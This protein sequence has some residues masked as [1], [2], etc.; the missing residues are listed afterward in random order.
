MADQDK[1]GTD[2]GDDELDAIVADYFAMLR[3]EKTG[4]PFVK[5]HHRRALMEQI[6]RT[7]R[8]VE[9]KHMNISAVLRCLGLPTIKGYKPKFHVQAGI[10]DAV[11]RYLIADPTALSLDQAIGAVARIAGVSEASALFEEPPPPLV[12]TNLAPQSDRLARLVRKFDPT[13]RDARNRALGRAGEALIVDFERTRLAQEDRRD[14]ASKVRWV[15]Q[16]D[17]DGAGYDI[18][19]FDRTGRERLIEVKTTH[20][21]RTT[22]FFL[23][24]NERS[25]SD[26][27]PD[28]FRLYRVYEFGPAPR[29]FKLRPPL[30]QAVMLEP[31]TYRASFR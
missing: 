15:A 28:A 23:S 19:S 4:E 25:L 8:S 1:L 22:P 12:A 21:I 6:G 13:E 20:G 26:E 9:F 10:V 3:A 7:N 14:L 17:G 31:T 29:L 18:L 5:A 24:S 16:E 27:R 2:W 30:H 11:E